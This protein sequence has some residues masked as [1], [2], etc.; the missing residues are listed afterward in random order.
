[1]ELMISPNSKKQIK[2]YI[3]AG[4]STFLFG[5]KDYAV[6]NSLYLSVDEIKKLR[7][8]YPEIT[9]FISI[10]KML[11]NDDIDK[12]AE[13]LTALDKLNIKGLFFYDL[14]LITLKKR[15]HLSLALVWNQTHMVTNYK[16]CNYYYEQ[17]VEY[18]T[19]A[20]EITVEEILQINQNT[21]IK[22]IMSGLGFPVVSHTKR[23]L[24]TNYFNYYHKKNR[25][26]LYHINCGENK[27]FIYE[28]KDGSTIFKDSLLNITSILDPLM[29]NDIPYLILNGFN[30]NTNQF[31]KLVLAFQAKLLNCLTTEELNKQINKIYS[32]D[33]NF[34]FKKTIYK[35]RQNED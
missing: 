32:N 33:S 18:A 2:K 19:V 35:V 14:A 34:F 6:H 4:S 27:Y 31:N 29:A 24:L 9:L 21:N 30:I 13:I 1:M 28:E 15:L 3:K 26:K 7:Q 8:T 12:L 11:F 22:L 20:N 10:N 17:G 25:K 23:K 16:T 5:L